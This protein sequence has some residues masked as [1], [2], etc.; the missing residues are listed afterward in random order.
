M[1]RLEYL[2]KSSALFSRLVHEVKIANAMGHF[3]INTVSEDFLV[4]IL[5]KVFACPDLKN[6][7][8]INMNFPA[9]DLGC[10]TS[11]TSIQITSDPSSAKINETL[12][13]FRSHDL[14]RDFDRLLIYVITEKQGS[15]RSKSLENEIERFPIDFD[16][17]RNIIDYRNVAAK[18]NELSLDII[19]CV[20]AILESE[21]KKQDAHLLFRENLEKFLTI[22]QEKIE[23]E[24]RTKKYIPSVFV[25]TTTIKEEMRFFANPMFFYRKIDDDIRRIRFDHLNDLLGLAKIE[26]IAANLEVVASL[27]EPENL[28]ALRERVAHQKEALQGA[29]RLVSPFSYYVDR[30]ARFEPD[31]QTE[32]YWEVF[33]HPI[34]SNSSGVDRALDDI[35]SRIELTQSKIFLITSMAGQG[36]TNFVCDIVEHQ[37]NS[38]DIPSIFIPARALNDYPGPN[39][40]LAY[41]QNN[42]F[43]PD[44]GDLHELMKLLDRVASESQRPFIIA[45][46][47]INEIGP[48]EDFCTELR[49]FLDVVCQY[50]FVKVLITCRSEFFDH[51]FAK[52]FD[53][54]SS[55]HLHRV[56]DL[57]SNMSKENRKRLLKSY[58]HY[59]KIKTELSR[60]AEKFLESDLILL[61]IFCEIH[62]GADIGSVS[63]IYKGDVFETYL[64]KKIDEFPMS[65]RRAVLQ[66]LYKIC[67]RMLEIEQFS[68][69]SVSDFD[70]FEQ[71]VIQQLIGEDIVLRRE[72]PTTG[73]SSIGIE[74]ISFTY[75]ELR[76]FILS[77][78]VTNELASVDFG[79]TKFI[80]ERLPT[81][82]IYE[83]F[84]RYSY[85]L[86]RKQKNVPILSLCEASDN[87]DKHYINNLPLLSAD[88]QDDRDVE[89]VKQILSS[90]FTDYEI[91]SV[92]WFLFRKRNLSEPL[93]VQILVDYVLG[94]RDPECKRFIVKIFSWPHDYQQNHWLDRVDEFLRSLIEMPDDQKIKKKA[95]LLAFAIILAGFARW[96]E[97]EALLNNFTEL[98]E[99]SGIRQ[100]LELCRE[101][102]SDQVRR[103]VDEIAASRED[104]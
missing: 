27:A 55:N 4:P 38:F 74:N 22:N 70:P 88:V 13:K 30:E 45:I 31:E 26:P 44:V 12:R 43:A 3:D 63:D 68:Q 60:S 37:F 73:L 100:A 79:L 62:E 14:Q 65:Q 48:L 84:F 58:V 41:I 11:R 2:H 57:R 80:F 35:I 54:R 78:F 86:A 50:D 18:L 99:S 90:E 33:R 93:N 82:T 52:V 95:P 40:L 36:K 61:R 76:D 51:K 69:I 102:F 72:V 56:E 7:N 103:C 47:G 53:D 24:K 25:E 75:D 8:R 81:W 23:A 9:V 67:G 98:R 16:A 42:R 71:E 66:T 21:F 77:Y 49:V 10:E 64:V 6:Q 85:L 46:D 29:K 19:Q 32:G 101:A 87:F 17:S 96:E 89:R 83:G 104:A 91:R 39:R 92:A 5:S 34:E 97:R 1:N 15:Y 28:N 59:F 20:H 94:L